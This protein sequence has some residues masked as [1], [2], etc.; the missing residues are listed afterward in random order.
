MVRNKIALPLARKKGLLCS[1]SKKR[2]SSKDN[3]NWT[4]LKE[5]KGLS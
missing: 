5:L 2:V 4:C 1:I 3:R